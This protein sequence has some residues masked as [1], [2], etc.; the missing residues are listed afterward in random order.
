MAVILHFLET[1]IFTKS[2]LMAKNILKPQHMYIFKK[3]NLMKI[4]VP[5]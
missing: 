1:I 3:L 2:K 4:K 5:R